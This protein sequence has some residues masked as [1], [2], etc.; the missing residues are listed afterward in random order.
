MADPL[1]GTWRLLAFEFTDAEGGKF[2]PLGERPTGHVLFTRDGYMSLNFAA[3]D[4][5]PFAADDLFAGGAA[6]RAAAAEG[7]VCFS[8]PYSIENGAVVVDVE[9]SLFPNWVG[10]PQTRLYSLDGDRL[11]LRTD[12]PRLFGGVERTAEARLERAVPPGDRR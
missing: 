4:R 9:F 1:V 2:H 12:G 3:R 5:V 6:E 11:T 7:V 8:G 10:R